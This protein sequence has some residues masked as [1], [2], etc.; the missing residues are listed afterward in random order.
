VRLQDEL[1]AAADLLLAHRA[2][3]HDLFERPRDTFLDA[4]SKSNQG[5]MLGC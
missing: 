2:H 4:E 5:P 3:G 1:E